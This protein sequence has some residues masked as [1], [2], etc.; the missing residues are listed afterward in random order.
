MTKR[1]LNKESNERY[2][3]IYQTPVKKTLPVKEEG[4]A[5]IKV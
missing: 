2:N 4:F 5:T 3:T 1:P